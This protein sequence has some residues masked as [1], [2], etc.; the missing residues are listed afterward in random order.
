MLCYANF[1][2]DLK[3]CLPAHKVWGSVM[4]LIVKAI[5]V[6]DSEVVGL[7][8]LGLNLGSEA[9]RFPAI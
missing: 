7:E 3:S 6:Q 4:V 2:A 5:R 1:D 9:S 8:V